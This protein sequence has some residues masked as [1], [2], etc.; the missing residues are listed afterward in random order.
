MTPPNPSPNPF[1]RTHPSPS[2]SKMVS[3]TTTARIEEVLQAPV[4]FQDF[5]EAIQGVKT[6]GAPGPS[7]H[8]AN[9]LKAWLMETTTIVYNHICNIWGVTDSPPPGSRTRRSS[10]LPRSPATR[11]PEEYE[12]TDHHSRQT[13]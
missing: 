7:N 6:N 12:G 3:P 4:T 10:S 9:M 11:T 13:H 5:T 8:T 2:H 1:T